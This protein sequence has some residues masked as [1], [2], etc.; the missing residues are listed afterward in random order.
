[1]EQTERRF[2]SELNANKTLQR[3]PFYDLVYHSM[4][5]RFFRGK[6]NSPCLT[7]EGENDRLISLRREIS[8]VAY[9]LIITAM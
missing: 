4:N 8:K 1:M 9:G 6:Y 5:G 7:K 2:Y 3:N